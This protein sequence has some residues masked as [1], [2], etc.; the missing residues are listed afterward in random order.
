MVRV[1]HRYG[2]T[3]SASPK[4]A[5]VV[6]KVLSESLPL[7]RVAEF[8]LD[9]ANSTF[10]I[11]ATLPPSTRSS[12]LRFA[13]SFPATMH[14]ST[15]SEEHFSKS[16]TRPSLYRARR[17]KR[18]SPLRGTLRPEPV[19]LRLRRG[20]IGEQ[21]LLTAKDS[22]TVIFV[23]KVRPWFD[24][25]RPTTLEAGRATWN[26]PLPLPGPDE[27]ASIV[28]GPS[29][30][31]TAS[32]END[33]DAIAR[34]APPEPPQSVAL[35]EFVAGLESRRLPTFLVYSIWLIKSLIP[36]G[37]LLWLTTQHPL[38]EEPA[39]SPFV[40]AIVMLAVFQSWPFL[41]WISV[42]TWTPI[43]RA[44]W[45][46]FGALGASLEKA[47]VP[48]A[49]GT[50]ALWLLVTVVL[51]L[52]VAYVPTGS[53]GTIRSH[54]SSSRFFKWARK[55]WIGTRLIV[56]AFALAVWYTA[57]NRDWLAP[58]IWDVR[59]F[60]FSLRP[61]VPSP[62]AVALML[63]SVLLLVILMHGIRAMIFGVGVLAV[64]LKLV[65]HSRSA[66]TLAPEMLRPLF[67]LP[68]NAFL[69]G[70]LILT[71]PIVAHLLWALIP[72]APEK[73]RWLGALT[74]TGTAMF[75]TSL[76]AVPLLVLAGLVI[77]GCLGWVLFRGMAEFDDARVLFEWVAAHKGVALTVGIAGALLLVWPVTTTP[78][79]PLAFGDLAYFAGS[80]RDLCVYALALGM[81]LLMHQ[82]A[83]RNGSVLLEPSWL[84]VGIWVFALF[85]VNST[86]S[87][88]LI[89]VPLVVGLLVARLWLF[90]PH[91][92]TTPI[93]EVDSAPSV[94]R[95]ALIQGVLDSIQARSNLSAVRKKLDAKL[96]AA[97]LVPEEYQPQSKPIARIYLPN[98]CGSVQGKRRNIAGCVSAGPRQ[99]VDKYQGCRLDRRAAG[100]CSDF[101]CPLPVRTESDG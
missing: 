44:T 55:A 40:R 87:W 72:W 99:S 52:A 33:T 8:R 7:A 41:A 19:E 57:I 100:C 79:R 96:A 53:L 45:E 81:L 31:P 97:E 51:P 89:P 38:N 60:P 93:A 94:D 10:R 49:I 37:V 36:F 95:R 90:S 25:I 50:S 6:A 20:G 70:V 91:H 74:L 68:W 28:F 29:A 83:L 88:L 4:S 92:T 67:H 13:G 18:F 35:K 39:W 48:F 30:V 43:Y 23:P 27:I 21:P 46:I 98:S 47:T 85:L 58:G 3:Q 77:V 84:T 2:D 32:P 62:I 5:V 80:A 64:A 101:D 12:R 42:D 11:T 22:L 73:I 82:R 78:T 34:K 26:G 75:F 24:G 14:C 16:Q 65:M 15:R 69:G 71:L 66:I 76:P 9:P 86:T 54:S 1:R 59:T 63:L 56:A 61:D 17:A